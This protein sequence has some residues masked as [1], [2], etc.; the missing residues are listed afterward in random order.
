MSLPK[1]TGPRLPPSLQL[2]RDRSRL[3]RSPLATIYYPKRKRFGY[4]P[5]PQ[6]NA[7][8]FGSIATRDNLL[9]KAEALPPSP[10]L[11]RTGRLQAMSVAERL[12]V[13]FDRYPRQLTIQSGS[14]SSFAK[15]TADRSATSH[16]R[17]R[18]PSRL[19]RSPPA[20]TDYPKR[21]RFGYRTCRL[22]A[23][24]APSAEL[25]AKLGRRKSGDT[26]KR[27]IELGNRIETRFESDFA[28]AEMG[29]L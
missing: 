23:R 22:Q 2:R 15:A 27:A 9:P 1:G 10:R 16:V 18:T 12:R 3:V 5:R 29:I 17:N 26:L 20:T 4:K 11:R 6:P 14:A 8:A 7:F 24:P 21:K 28:H 13:W 25:A 19:V